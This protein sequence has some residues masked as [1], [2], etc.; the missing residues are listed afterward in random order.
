MIINNQKYLNLNNIIKQG[1]VKKCGVLKIL[2]DKFKVVKK[3]EAIVKEFVES[4]YIAK[5]Y[6]KEIEPLIN[7]SHEILNPLRV[8]YLFKNIP[9]EVINHFI[10]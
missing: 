2:H 1:V 4:F 10:L 3:N 7:K 9:E 6:N 8:L 5:E